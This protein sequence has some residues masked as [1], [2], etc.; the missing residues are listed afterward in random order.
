M[1]TNRKGKHVHAFRCLICGRTYTN[2]NNAN[3]HVCACLKQRT[4]ESAQSTLA[5]Y[6]IGTPVPSSQPQ[7]SLE[8]ASSQ[9]GTARKEEPIQMS[10]RDVALVEL[11][12]DA[13][14]P[15][16]QIN[17][18]P[19]LDF[20]SVFSPDYEVPSNETIRK[21][22][23]QHADDCLD[24]G[25]D[26]MKHEVCGVAVDG[27]TLMAKHCYA[28]ILVNP[29]GLRLAAI[30]EVRKQDA[31][32][33]CGIIGEVLNDCRQRNIFVSG[34]VSDN[35]PAL[36][37]ALI[38][39]EANNENTLLA[40]VGNEVIRCAC[41]AHTGQLV[42]GDLI[43][44]SSLEEFFNDVVNTIQFL[45]THRDSFITTCPNKIPS[46]ISTRWN[47][48]YACADFLM[49][50][51]EAIDS[52]I[53]SIALSESE[54]YE[55]KQRL[56][57]LGKI[58][59]EPTPPTP[60]PIPAIPSHWKDYVNALEVI[61]DFTDE[62]EKDLTLQ[63]HVYVA[64]CRVFRRL[65]ELDTPCANEMRDLFQQRFTST[66]DLS[67]SKLAYYLTPTGLGEYRALPMRE[68]GQ[69]LRELKRKFQA[70]TEKFPAAMTLYFPAMYTFYMN[71]YP[72]NPGD[73][74]FYVFSE[75]QNEEHRIPGINGESPVSFAN[76]AIACKGLVTLPASEAMVERCFSQIKS[77]ST[78]FNKRMKIDFAIALSTLKLAIRYRRKYF[79]ESP[80]FP[81][82]E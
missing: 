31:I 78:D 59:T 2:H 67:L 32:T 46:Y 71:V 26:E 47:T 55:E 37:K 76:F 80:S 4:T 74:P 81:I 5:A 16:T 42:I 6:G 43:K 15:Y 79:F 54:E 12:A 20:L 10:K 29:T 68:R 44:N 21:M 40:I 30:K 3:A 36:V 18:Q 64:V 24:K 38:D 73:S 28:F 53:E 14:I 62:V 52:F 58:R 41:S 22:I 51:R 35:A 66:A 70:L 50:H 34:V 63:Q 65:E 11:I 8:Q 77:I 75:L 72:V 25:L 57:S 23:K 48:L 56:F 9:E 49:E 33:L 69:L 13:N 27:A 7:Q 60:P 82:D 17:T 19:W 45:K 39:N 61:S 1:K